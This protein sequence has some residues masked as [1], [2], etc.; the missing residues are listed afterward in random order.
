ML[1]AIGTQVAATTFYTTDGGSFLI[2][3]VFAVVA[4][5]AGWTTGDAFRQRRVHADALRSQV[6]VQAAHA[7]RLRIARVLHDMIAHSIGV[8]AIQAGMAGRVIHSQPAEARNALDAIEATSRETL[9]ELRQV[10]G[11]FRESTSDAEPLS[12]APG[13]ADLQRI[14]TAAENSGVHVTVRR[15]GDSRPLPA[16]IDLSAFRIVQE[17]LTNVVRHANARECRVTI[18]LRTAEL[19]IEIIDDGRSASA[20]GTGY[21]IVGMRERSRLLHGEFDAGPR[22][23]GGFRVMARIPVPAA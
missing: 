7:E 6:A 23:E 21:G 20:P 10:L 17:A 5:F 16:H 18:E 2:S 12:P 11:G 9:A 22:P 15:A 19:A 3:V 1:I 8:I 4:V 13:L 14:A